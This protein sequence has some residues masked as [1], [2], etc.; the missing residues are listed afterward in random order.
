MGT[1][2][3][4]DQVEAAAVFSNIYDMVAD[5]N[6][7]EGS[8]ISSG[9]TLW[10]VVTT[11]TNIDLGSGLYAE[12][13]GDIWADDF[14]NPA[15]TDDG[16]GLRLMRDHA[17]ALSRRVTLRSSGRNYLLQ[18]TETVPEY[19][20]EVGLYM[21]DINQVKINFGGSR[22]SFDINEAGL[23]AAS[24]DAVL[25]L[26]PPSA[27]D[28]DYAFGNIQNLEL[29]GGNWPTEAERPTNVMKG[30]YDILAYCLFEDMLLMYASD[31]VWV[32]EGFVMM[33][34]KIRARFAGVNGS[35]IQMITTSGAKTGYLL[36][37]CT[38]DFAG[39]KGFQ[40]LGGSG[41]T[42]CHL[43]NCHADFVGRD[44]NNVTIGANVGTAYAYSVSDIR[45][46]N[47]TA[48][49]AEFC[50]GILRTNN[51]RSLSIDGLFSL[52]AGHSDGVTQ[53]DNLIN[54]TG[55]AEQVNIQNWENRSPMAGGSATTLAITNPV[56]FNTNSYQVDN[57]LTEGLIR[58]DGGNPTSGG[59]PL[60]TAPWQN[61]EGQ[62]RRGA[63]DVVMTGK[64]LIGSS[65]DDWYTSED[66]IEQTFYVDN[67]GVPVPRD[68]FEIKSAVDG[69][70]GFKVEIVATRS[71]PIAVSDFTGGFVIDS[72]TSSLIQP[73]AGDLPLSGTIPTLAFAD[74]KLTVTLPNSLTGYYIKV[75]GVQRPAIGTAIRINWL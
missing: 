52:G 62:A 42:Y 6:I 71:L 64:N 46:L 5:R 35:G 31:S 61:Y 7:V 74:S 17:E 33:L 2:L 13:L 75:T 3:A 70:I 11:A 8:R 12:A 26:A 20:G 14:V 23:G 30:D 18:S 67:S 59:V 66:V 69:V 54:C 22:I 47:M 60:V 34:T 49:G 27:S 41:H 68:L 16:V 10:A 45:V 24:K 39:L 63:G 53:V 32:T 65:D 21:T 48:C 36:D 19:G 29:S 50:T 15:D 72:A 38:V 73:V 44:D 57:S 1:K 9:L 37:C 4:A 55:F 58:F 43:N 28:S 25:A 51:P 56:A 40:M